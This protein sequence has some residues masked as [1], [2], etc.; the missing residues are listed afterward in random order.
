MIHDKDLKTWRRAFLAM[1]LVNVGT[2]A[3]NAFAHRW[4]IVLACA[5]WA[6][7][8]G[9]LH[10]YTSTQQKTRDEQRVTQA[11]IR[12]LLERQEP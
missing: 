4:T 9:M 10:G 1:V 8:C 5:V 3:L 11:G 12:S 7:C 2:G 6:I